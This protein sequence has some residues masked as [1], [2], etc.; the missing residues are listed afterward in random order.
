MSRALRFP[1][2]PRDP[3]GS[4]R[5]SRPGAEDGG[6]LPAT[7]SPPTTTTIQPVH[8]RREGPTDR[9]CGVDPPPRPLVDPGDDRVLLPR[10]DREFADDLVRDGRVQRVQRRGQCVDT[11]VPHAHAAQRDPRQPGHHHDRARRSRIPAHRAR[12]QVGREAVQQGQRGPFPPVVVVRSG[13]KRLDHRVGSEFEGVG[14]PRAVGRHPAQSC[15]TGAPATRAR[16]GPPAAH[17]EH[18]ARRP[19]PAARS[20]DVR[21][22]AHPRRRAE[23]YRSR[24]GW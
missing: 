24:T 4:W 1:G 10:P 11:L 16:R 21:R 23:P 19:Q 9:A 17:P 15:R 12:G 22:D 18:G 20:P 14:T 7:E 8:A 3:P 5:D 6:H 2:N 13:A